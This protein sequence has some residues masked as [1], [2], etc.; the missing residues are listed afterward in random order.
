M[1][2]S[3]HRAPKFT[4][5]TLKD[6]ETVYV[7]PQD[8]PLLEDH[9]SRWS[10]SGRGIERREAGRLVLLHRVIGE[11]LHGAPLDTHRGPWVV[12][13]DGDP[14]NCLRENLSLLSHK[15]NK[16]V[17]LC[18]FSPA[19]LE[20]LRWRENRSLLEIAEEAARV[21]GSGVLPSQRTVQQWLDAA[22]VARPSASQ[23][24]RRKLRKYDPR[25]SARKAAETKRGREAN[26]QA[27]A[28]WRESG[29]KLGREHHKKAV[30]ALREKVWGKKRLTLTCATCGKAFERVRCYAD[31]RERQ[32][33]EAN[34]EANAPCPHFCSRACANSANSREHWRAIQLEKLIA[35]SGTGIPAGHE[36]ATCAQCG[37]G[38]TVQI[39]QMRARRKKA[40]EAGHPERLFCSTS[41]ANAYKMA[42]RHPSGPPL[43]SLTCSWCNTAFERE[44]AQWRAEQSRNPEVRPYCS[45]S[46]SVK[47][48]HKAKQ[49]ASGTEQKRARAREML[50]QGKSRGEIAVELGIPKTTLR[51]WI[52][53][54][55]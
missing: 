1:P 12:H 2:E 50:A 7:S 53:S 45:R 17:A 30:E 14:R 22:G 52:V 23:L 36:A 8:A 13:K 34:P 16:Q 6:G 21:E 40:E 3:A 10:L 18:P 35:S 49:E 24:T 11:I 32:W 28:A 42:Q 48:Q 25:E 4:R 54:A 38:F 15:P 26:P 39:G 44:A 46:C 5:R 31:R 43:V 19:R 47:G 20:E 37:N 41:C 33:A 29:E 9:L 27:R 51:H 55:D